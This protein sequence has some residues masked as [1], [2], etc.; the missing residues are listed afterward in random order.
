[1]KTID[2]GLYRLLDANADRAAEAL[3]VVGDIARFVLDDTTLSQTWRTMRG[4]LWHILS[5]VPRLQQNAVESRDSA[6]DVGRD[7]KA[8]RHADLL[9]LARANI[10]RAQ[11][12]FRVLE[13]ACRSIELAAVPRFARLRYQCY[14]LEPAMLAR[15]ELRSLERKLDFHLYV[16]LGREFSKGRDFLEVTEKAIAGGAG[17]IQ[18]RDKEMSKRELLAWA[19]RLRELTRERGVTFIM[20]DHLD[21]A[22]AAGADGVH[23][24]QDDFPIPEARR[25]AGP[26]F[27]IGASTH[28]VDQARKAVEEGASYINIGPIF[29]TGTKKG[30]VT[31]VG[32]EMITEVTRIVS[33][34]F[35]VMGGIK[36]GNVD[37]VLR[38][39]ARRVAVVTAVVAADD[40]TAAARAFVTKIQSC[41]EGAKPPR[42][43]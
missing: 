38:R 23:L 17:A 29:P 35:T 30:V 31:P 26:H 9:Q 25:A 42:P 20:N 8:G 33:H 16:V 37:E 3:R 13:E 43:E 28:S 34:P 39:G 14:E 2:S 15:L 19:Y 22:L 36:L 10:H 6:G 24:G 1:M 4:E 12:S 27:I 5:S 32:P 18:L 40:I 21:I 41:T 11:E 7:F